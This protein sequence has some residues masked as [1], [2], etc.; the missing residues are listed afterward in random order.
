MGRLI[1]IEH[2]QNRAFDRE[3]ESRIG[4]DIEHFIG[5][6]IKIGIEVNFGI[7]PSLILSF[8]K[9]KLMQNY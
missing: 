4:I 3:S 7:V 5:I 1:G 8:S 9:L 6:S 2:L